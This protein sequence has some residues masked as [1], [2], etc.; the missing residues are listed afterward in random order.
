[1]F[2]ASARRH[3]EKLLRRAAGLENEQGHYATLSGPDSSRKHRE[4]PF[5]Q[6]H[7]MSTMLLTWGFTKWDFGV[8]LAFPHP[9][10]LLGKLAGAITP[11]FA[12]NGKL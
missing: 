3:C 8:F 1:M 6:F 10:G 5:T 7:V 11:S 2:R 12:T 4:T 9:D